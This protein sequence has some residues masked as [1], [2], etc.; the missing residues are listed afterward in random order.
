MGGLCSGNKNAK[1]EVEMQKAAD[2]KKAA[3]DAERDQRL[4]QIAATLKKVPLLA[5]LNDVER[6]TL[7][8]ALTEQS[9]APGAKIIV[10]GTEGKEFY[11]IKKGV[12]SVTKLDPDSG[13]DNEL[14]QLKEG[15]YFGEAALFNDAPRGAT[16]A[17]KSAVECWVMDQARFQALFGEGKKVEVKFAKRQ[18][19]R[20]AV[21]AE[22][23]DPNDAKGKNKYR[24]PADAVVDKD[25]AK[26]EMI[27][28]AVSQNMLFKN[29]EKEQ[30]E[31]IV[32][33]MWL[34][35][36]P[37][38][39]EI[40][41]QGDLGDN[42]YVV[43]RGNFQI[44]VNQA[45]AE[46]MMVAQRGNGS[47]F[48]ELALMYARPRAATVKAATDDCAVWVLDR[49]TFRSILAG[50]NE[51]KLQEYEEFL[52][53]VKSFEA[54]LD[55]ER[56]KIAEALET[57]S[58]PDGHD[59]IKEGEDGDEFFV[60][61]KGEVTVSIRGKEVARYKAGDYFGE[62]ALVTN[63]KRAATVTT[64]GPVDCLYL[65]R[66]SFTQLLGPLQDIF[67][68]RVQSYKAPTGG[69]ASPGPDVAPTDFVNKEQDKGDQQT[70]ENKS[71]ADSEK[72]RPKR[73]FQM[74][75]FEIIGVL[76]KGSFGLV[77]LVR[78]QG[79]GQTYALKSVSK[80]QIVQLGQQE[81]VVSEKRVMEELEHNTLIR[82][83]GTF[84]DDNLLHFVLEP[85]LGGELFSVLRA[86]TFFD[87]NTARFFAA[88]IVCAFQYMHDKGIIYR[89]LKPENLLLTSK[90]YLKITDFGFAKK[91][92][93]KR[94][95]TLCGTPD[96]LAPEVVSGQGH[97]KSVD[98]WTLGILIYEMLASYPPF[99]DDDP[100]K[101]YAKIMHGQIAFP[102]HFSKPAVD[103][104]KRLLHP[105]ATRRL[106]VLKGGARLIKQHP[107]FKT[108][109]WEAFENQT[110]KAPIILPVKGPEDLSNFENYEDEP[111][112]WEDYVPDPK[113]PDWDLEF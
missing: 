110:M 63:D 55:Y 4:Q 34:K 81:H 37:N 28:T 23:Y 109:D 51:R 69:V 43:D 96:Y 91:I 56:A 107:W 58:F 26:K 106:G 89:D 10:E 31:S 68:E 113:N 94:T 85:S 67:S 8:D 111:M 108:F 105:K 73:F 22:S 16:I 21:S 35:P 33:Q 71:D 90:G 66:T 93:E 62:R 1:E 65:D 44:F 17:A 76:G 30:Q 84:R 49:W 45:E 52:K 78:H 97:D 11:I 38:G 42:F 60:L 29:M 19:K 2:D 20:Q 13:Q 79:D 50:Q 82:L 98:W 72:P 39:E 80:A 57:V 104:I 103:L 7:A 27:V 41:R 88:G 87:E 101:T 48:G 86:R 70:E 64:V 102:M 61:K 40:I 95:W 83:Y 18:P 9:F 24:R 25:A 59:I 46:P 99:Y 92:K 100:M 47:S 14:A 6:S 36:V 112:E 54:L 77:Q 74:T 32:D 5:K 15:D 12:T 53:K 75:D 3:E